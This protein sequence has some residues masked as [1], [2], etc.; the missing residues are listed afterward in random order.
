[1][2]NLI[3]IDRIEYYLKAGASFIRVTE[4]NAFDPKVDVSTYEAQYKDRVNQPS[5]VTGK[6]T[7]VDL[8]IDIVDPGALQS[9]LM[10]NE[11]VSNVPTEIVRVLRFRP[12]HPAWAASVVRALGARIIAGGNLYECT[13]AG[14]TGATQP[15]TWTTTTVT[16]GTVTWTYIGSA[17]GYP[18]GT[19]GFAAKKANFT[20]TQNP[21]DG[22][23][24]EAVRA[25]GTLSMTSDG[26]TAGT[27]DTATRTFTPAV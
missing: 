26:W 8:D 27:F 12:A 14:T 17:S 3:T 7:T 19:S 1:M 9:W 24:G 22:G 11:D 15:A 23:A 13:T 10:A 5:Y 2:T 25:T 20:L 18:I 16:D 6:K 4:V 21:I